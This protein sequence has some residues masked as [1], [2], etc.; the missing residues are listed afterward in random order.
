MIVGKHACQQEEE[1]KGGYQYC[2]EISGTIIYFRDLQ[3]HT[4][5]NLIDPLLQDSVKIQSGLFQQIYHVGCA[6]NLHFI[7]NNGM[8]PGGQISSNRHTVIF[9]PI[10][11]R[12]KGHQDPATIDFNKPRRAQY[13]HS[14][15]KKHQDAVFWV[16]I[17][18][19]IQKGIDILSDSIE[20]N[21]PSRNTSSSL[22]SKSYEIE[23]WRS[24]I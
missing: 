24:L 9:L 6:F 12:D 23:D 19:A 16:D 22:Y 20:C 15:W 1:R 4:G 7:I 3:G 11:P 21:H 14:A 5:S 8:I 18:L 13:M 17:N 10:D 2:T